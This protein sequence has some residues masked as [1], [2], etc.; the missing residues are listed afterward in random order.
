[1]QYLFRTLFGLMA[2]SFVYMTST[3]TSF[4]GTTAA[5]GDRLLTFGLTFLDRLLP[6][7]PALAGASH[8]LRPTR[9]VTFL[10]T[11]LHRLAQA[12]SLRFAGKD[13]MRADGGD[14][15]DDDDDG[16]DPAM[17]N[18]TLADRRHDVMHC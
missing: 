18:S 14:D 11:G 15:D 8:P 3:S 6:F 7:Q 5:L 17:Q 10:T 12:R 1:M 4:L 13:M 16:G 9:D 2:A